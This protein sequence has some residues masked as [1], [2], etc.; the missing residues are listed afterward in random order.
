MRL[1]WETSSELCLVSRGWILHKNISLVDYLNPSS[2]LLFLFGLQRLLHRELLNDLL[3]LLEF[4]F[5]LLLLL[6]KSHHYL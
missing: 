6:Q 4:V 5:E 2:V 3:L 1:R